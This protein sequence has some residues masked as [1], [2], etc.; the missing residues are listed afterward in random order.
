[1]I[2][3]LYCPEGVGSTAKLGIVSTSLLLLLLPL[4]SFADEPWE[5][6][7]LTA[8]PA[9]VLR[10]A[11]EGPVPEG[12]HFVVLLNEG[13]YV[14][15]AEGRCELTRRVVYRVISQEGSQALA[16]VQERWAPWYQER[17]AI[18]ARVITADGTAHRLDPKTLAEAPVPSA[19][20]EVFTD[21]RSLQ[22]PLPA[23]AP[24]AVVE[25][26][27]VLR[28]TAPFFGR[29]VTRYYY[30]GAQAPI[31]RVRLV[32]E[33][34][35]SLP[36]RY[37][38]RL[39]PNLEP[40]RSLAGGRVTLTFEAGPFEPLEV[41]E[42]MTPTDVPTWP[43]LAFTTGKTWRDVVTGYHQIV[44]KQIEAADLGK[45]LEGGRPAKGRDE[46]LSL[47]LPRLHRQVRYTSVAFGDASIVPRTPAET[48]QRRY[49]DCKDKSALLVAALRK[50]NI[51]A[52]VALLNTGP[53]LDVEPE[54][55][56]FGVFDHAIVYIPGSP[57]TWIDATEKFSRPGELPEQV[58]G[59]LALIVS[60]DTTAL[61]RTP[62]SSSKE[63][64][65]VEFREFQLEEFGKSRVVETTRAWGSIERWYR[66][67]YEMDQKMI[68]Q[69]LE[70]YAKQAFLS[71]KL[72]KFSHSEPSDLSKPFEL[73]LEMAEAGRGAS[74]LREAV[75]AVPLAG[76]WG[77]LPIFVTL[78]VAESPG[79]K[80]AEGKPWRTKDLVMSEPF[81]MEW[82]YRIVPP[83]GFRARPLPENETVKLGP[84]VLS[85]EYQLASD[86]AVKAIFR[87]DTVKRRFTPEEATALRDGLK[88]IQEDQVLVI[89]FE[90]VGQAH[91]EAGRILEALR[92]FR[93][94]AETH[95]REGLHRAQVAH[96]LLAAG[97]GDAARQEAQAAV[98]LESSSVVAHQAQGW[99]L[100]HDWI[101]RRFRKGWEP[102]GAEA[103]YRKALEREPDN[104][105][106]KLDLAILLEHDAS[107][108]RYGPGS[109]LSDA[110]A[111]YHSVADQVKGTEF[112]NNLPIALMRA[113]RFPELLKQV[114]DVKTPVGWELLLVA[115][116]ATEG[117][118]AAI[119][120]ASRSIA[121][122]DQ[123]RAALQG[124]G[125]LLVQLR[126]YPQAAELLAAAARGSK[127][128]AALLG[129]AEILRKTRRWEDVPLVAN[130]PVLLV[131]RFMA[132]LF[133]PELNLDELKKVLSRYALSELE[134]KEEMRGLRQVHA[135]VVGALRESGVP[136]EVVRDTALS[137]VEPSVEGEAS[138]GFRVRMP[139]PFAGPGLNVLFTIA[140]DGQQRLLGSAENELGQ[141]V[142]DL[143]AKGEMEKAQRW[144]DWAREELPLSG[145][146]D[147]LAGSPFA[148]LW[149]K[150]ASANARTMRWAAASLA[151]QG[152]AG[153]RA[154]EI[155]EQGRGEASAETVRP[156][157]D[158]ALTT[159]R[160]KHKRYQEAVAGARR[161]LIAAPDSE[162]AFQLLA[163][164][165]SKLR[166]WTEVEGAAQERLR[167]KPDDV[168]ALRVLQMNAMHRGD[169]AGAQKYGRRLVEIG[170]AEAVDLNNLAW[171]ALVEGMVTDEAVQTAQRAVMPP[172]PPAASSL[173]TLA[174]LYAELGKASEA[175]DVL[176][177]A[178]KL[179]G[180]D[181]PEPHDWFVLGRIAEHYS[182]REAAVAAY[183]KSKPEEDADLPN[184]SYQLALRRL[185]ALEKK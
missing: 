105:D 85:K 172:N 167:R 77:R 140:E 160:L 57:G 176:L 162:T 103:T 14:F 44:E 178:L 175:R 158:L 50:A 46:F 179:R 185:R 152:L 39:L 73:R 109:K 33:A 32:L 134:D 72:V 97:L 121:S 174:A 79:K 180:D 92:E 9:A 1:M 129:R 164:A 107:G 113:R 147:R 27:Y 126:L 40:R 112:Q 11:R 136:L 17:P 149:T 47:F 169:G 153:S 114:Q 53:G 91:L 65:S 20:P 138:F 37:V 133:T 122:D 100:Q 19:E 93:S 80:G 123:R 96:A 139:P 58:Q 141:A 29:G 51:P 150:G 119:R 42:P 52:H 16:A 48:L 132:I 159:A 76:L 165:L 157:L 89:G 111:L 2:R 90:Q 31:R 81:S 130:D 49:G 70:T 30:F 106:A 104:L 54:L 7:P 95:P 142:L 13:R 15:D 182:A 131:K 148:R 115:R 184:S 66:V 64:R 102:T 62:E 127:E 120:E 83:P 135:G 21:R 63:N 116:A 75:V 35:E 8:E 6:A 10:A 108:Q 56:G 84:A 82:Q 23:I 67:R 101:G 69:Q 87:F 181:E 177:Q 155:L 110:I 24:G 5:K 163:R 60:P 99:V 36:L 43:Y 94:L 25:V 55:P 18:R 74:D 68:R 28:D 137:A 45:L 38:T 41:G 124:A 146:E 170:K 144:L 128:A 154:I 143:I 71:D 117:A 166:K 183:R 86:G 26:E 78:D 22:G 161:L 173:H 98:G 145:G 156:A 88:K 125:N 171:A 3:M 59:R 34:P 168:S 118:S 151:A 12:T 61:V 4:F